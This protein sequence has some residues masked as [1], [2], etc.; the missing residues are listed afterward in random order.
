MSTSTASSQRRR[1]KARPSRAARRFGYVVAI[2]LNAAMLVAINAWPGWDVVPFLTDDTVDV[3]DAVNASIVVTLA[4]NVVYVFRDPPRVRAIGDA[5]TTVVGLVAMI[6]IW[7]VF[8]LDVS[9][10]WETV[11]RVLLGIG[12]VGSAIA[13]VTNLVRLVHPRPVAG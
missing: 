2:V 13:I 10:G 9:S 7:R 11:A 8:P 3:L 5:V 6:V 1:T 12:I 4:A